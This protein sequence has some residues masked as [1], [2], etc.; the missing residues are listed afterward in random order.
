MSFGNFSFQLGVKNNIEYGPLATVN[1]VIASVNTA[2]SADDTDHNSKSDIDD[3]SGTKVENDKGFTMT[4]EAVGS[5]TDDAVIE[6]QFK[7]D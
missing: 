5:I 1:E 6:N 4:D 7:I 2:Q 3:E